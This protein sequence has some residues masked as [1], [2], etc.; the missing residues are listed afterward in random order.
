MQIVDEDGRVF[1]VVNVVDLLVVLLIVAVVATGVALVLGS[2][3]SDADTDEEPQTA[4]VTVRAQSVQPYVAGALSTGPVEAENITR[5]GNVSVQPATIYTQNNSGAVLAGD[6]PRLK[7][8]ELEMIIRTTDS[9]N[10]TVF[11]TTPLRIGQRLDIDTG[12]VRLS[13]NVSSIEN[14]SAE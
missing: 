11:E 4:T 7:T 13:G 10:G 14:Q 3:D 8:V 2:G 6:H 1:G 5:I 9:A 12:T